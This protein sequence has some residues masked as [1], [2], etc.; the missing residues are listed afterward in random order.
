MEHEVKKYIEEVD[1]YIV[2]F[3]PKFTVSD[4]M[5]MDE[6]TY[7]GIKSAMKLLNSSKELS[8]KQAQIIDDQTRKLDLILAALERI[9]KKEES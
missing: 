2:Y 5:N 9:E 6:E 4:I 8:L 1:S 3:V 7:K